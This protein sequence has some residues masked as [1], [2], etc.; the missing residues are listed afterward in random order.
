[1]KATLTN[2]RQSPRKVGLVADQIRGK[3]VSVALA[4]LSFTDKKSSE[5]MIKVLNSAISNAINNNES[6]REDLFVKEIKI[7]KGLVIK[8]FRPRAR[9]AAF[10]IRRRTSHINIILGEIN[11][12]LQSPKE[13]KVENTEKEAK[14]AKIKTVEKKVAEKTKKTVAKKTAKKTV[15]KK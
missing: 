14:K 12:K 8:R 9:G 1:M 6:N 4:I 3:K 13:D 11:N 5:Q 15:S 10:P 7:D 2:Y